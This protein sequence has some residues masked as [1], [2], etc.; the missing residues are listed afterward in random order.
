MIRIG[1]DMGEEF[2]TNVGS[3]QGDGA[4]PVWFTSYYEA[5]LKEARQQAPQEEVV[6]PPE[7]QYADDLDLLDFCLG[8]LEAK[9]QACVKVFPAWNLKINEDKTERT[10]VFLAD[11]K[12]AEAGKEP[13]RHSKSLGSLL[14]CAADVQNRINKSAEAMGSLFA[15][16]KSLSIRK[17]TKL[18]LYNALVKPILLYNCGTWGLNKMWLEKLDATHR[19]HLRRL[20]GVFHPEHISNAKLYKLCQEE[21]VSKYIKTARWRL[22]GHILRLPKDAPAQRALDVYVTTT[23]P[24]RRGKHQ[25]GLLTMFKADLE[26][27]KNKPSRREIKL[28]GFARPDQLNNMRSLAMNKDGWSSLCSYINNS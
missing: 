7:M 22:L 11:T 12:S 15:L 3:P 4:S 9:L 17:E 2:E 18:R 26:A 21:P 24:G 14:D 27:F 13:W 19:R 1:S 20:L 5:A 23:A 28:M 16:W 10:H 8:K 25:T 6:L